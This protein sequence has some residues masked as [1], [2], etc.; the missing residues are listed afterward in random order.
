MEIKNMTCYEN[1]RK[2]E[3]TNNYKRL[4]SYFHAIEQDKVDEYH[5]QHGRNKDK[6]TH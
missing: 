4:M 1:L 2:K 6:K 3:K 5:N